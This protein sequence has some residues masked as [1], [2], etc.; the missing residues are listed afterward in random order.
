MGFVTTSAVQHFIFDQ[1]YSKK[2]ATRATHRAAERVDASGDLVELVSVVLVN[3]IKTEIPQ[4]LGRSVPRVCRCRP[5]R[6]TDACES[7][8]RRLTPPE[9]L[10]LQHTGPYTRDP[11]RVKLILHPDAVRLFLIEIFQESMS[12]VKQMMIRSGERDVTKLSIEQIARTQAARPQVHT[13]RTEYTIASPS[14]NCDTKSHAD[15]IEINDYTDSLSD[16][17]DPA[18]EMLARMY[19]SM[20]P[21]M[22]ASLCGPIASRMG[23]VAKILRGDGQS[24]ITMATGKLQNPQSFSKVVDASGSFHAHG[25]FEF[26][27]VEGFYDIKYGRTATLLNKEKVPKHIQNFENDSFKHADT[28]IRE[29][30]VGTLAFLLLD[31]TDPPP[32]LLLDDPME[33]RRQLV[34]AGGI[35]C[36]ESMFYAGIPSAHWK[37][38]AR[39]ADGEKCTKLEA[40]SFHA[41]RSWA[42]KPVET[43]VMLISLLA[44]QTTHPKIAEMVKQTAFF[45]WLGLDGSCV[46]ADQA[47]EFL[48]LLQDQRRGRFAAFES[49]LEFTPALGLFMHVNKALEEVEVG[50]REASDP[51]KAATINA[52]SVIRADLKARLGTDLTVHDDHNPIFRTG[53]A[54]NTL[55]STASLSHR[56]YEFIWQVA[57]GRCNGAGRGATRPEAWDTYVD[58]F[59]QENLW[60]KAR[61]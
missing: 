8:G 10:A 29:D 46:Y 18:A 32:E 12:F 41:Q 2:G 7:L 27:A 4:T 60:T 11:L 36:F 47:C 42:H 16:K 35:A 5:V 25:H 19:P 34:C 53:G 45:S 9:I 6:P 14:L 30:L 58:R 15:A 22:Q 24:V 61:Y 31:V 51:L 23:T 56:P 55:R 59:I 20:P 50:D 49:A 33:Y 26:C 13:P 1:K 17:P 43:R 57:D 40:Y 44:S 37:L 48:N 52:A 39:S 21:P 38:A 3:Y 54:P 28:H